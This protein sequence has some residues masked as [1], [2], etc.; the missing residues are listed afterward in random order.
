MIMYKLVE[1]ACISRQFSSYE[2]DDGYKRW[3]DLADGDLTIG[4]YST[5]EL[6]IKKGESLGYEFRDGKWYT[7]QK[8]AIFDDSPDLQVNRHLYI[9]EIEAE[10]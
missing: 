5:V 7:T 8:T 3:F 4:Y 6:A 1:Y 9:K 10:E 2:E